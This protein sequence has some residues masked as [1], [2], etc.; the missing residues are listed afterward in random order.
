VRRLVQPLEAFPGPAGFAGLHV[1]VP[2]G[3]D[4]LC[5]WPLLAET[6]C[7]PTATGDHVWRGSPRRDRGAND[8]C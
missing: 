8:G 4:A 1:L 7:T 6:H 3:G 2:L 5:T